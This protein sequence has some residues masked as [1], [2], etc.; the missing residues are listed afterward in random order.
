[1]RELE[2]K[3]K[4]LII[5]H[6]LQAY[7]LFDFEKYFTLENSTLFEDVNYSYDM[8]F[9]SNIEIS[10]RIRQNKYLTFQDL[11]IRSKSKANGKTEIDKIQEGKAQIYFYAYED[12]Q[13][14]K[15]TQINICD[16]DIIRKLYEQGKYYKGNN[17]DNTEF[18]SFKFKDIER[19]A[20]ENNMLFYRFNE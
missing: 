2:L 10:V 19:L 12:K 16:V 14:N 5:K 4:P 6:L 1:M 17:Y 13:R 3:Y 8:V 9:K 18:F 7:P 11:T 15:L 20:K